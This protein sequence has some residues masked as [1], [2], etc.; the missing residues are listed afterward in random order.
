[1]LVR[2]AP[3]RKPP[4]SSAAGFAV[5]GSAS[6]NE[7]AVDSFEYTVTTRAAPALAWQIYTD[8][9]RWPRFSDMYGAIDWIKGEPWQVGSR[10][11][12]RIVKPVPTTVEHVITLCSPPD[13]LAWI[14]HALGTTMEQ[15]VVFEALASGGTR[16]ITSAAFTGLTS[17]LAGLALKQVLIEF[18]RTW[19]DNFRDECDAAARQQAG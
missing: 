4:V 11:R 2:P 14:D 8:W 19:Y 16:V 1:M 7:D 5:Q 15:W 17:F 18:T 3:R 9:R 13:K 12:I 10:L 6:Y